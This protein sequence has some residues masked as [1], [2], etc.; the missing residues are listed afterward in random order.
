MNKKLKDNKSSLHNI[1]FRDLYWQM[2]QG[3][4]LGAAKSDSIDSNYSPKRN[5][6]NNNSNSSLPT[7]NV[8]YEISIGTQF[9]DLMV[10]LPSP[11][12]TRSK[13]SFAA[14]LYLQLLRNDDLPWQ[15][16]DQFQLIS[17]NN[18]TSQGGYCDFKSRSIDNIDNLFG[19]DS[20]EIDMNTYTLSVLEVETNITQSFSEAFGNLDELR[21]LQLLLYESAVDL[22]PTSQTLNKFNKRLH[23]KS[24]ASVKSSGLFNFKHSSISAN[25]NDQPESPIPDRPD[26]EEPTDFQPL[27][28]PHLPVAL[29]LDQSIQCLVASDFDP[30]C[31]KP[32]MNGIL[33]HELFNFSCMLFQ[34]L[35]DSIVDTSPSSALDLYELCILLLDHLD[36]PLEKYLLQKDVCILAVKLD[37]RE[38][39]IHHGQCVLQTM[40]LKKYDNINVL[41]Y[42]SEILIS[43]YESA[44][45]F[46]LAIKMILK[47]VNV[48]RDQ[49]HASV[50]SNRSDPRCRNFYSAEFARLSDPLILRLG[51]IFLTFGCEDKAADVLQQLLVSFSK[52]PPSM[53]CDLKKITVL[54]WLLEAYL[55][56]NN[57][58]ICNRIVE[59]IKDIRLQLRKPNALD[60]SICSINSMSSMS[61]LD[62]QLVSSASND[63]SNTHVSPQPPPNVNNRL[64]PQARS[65]KKLITNTDDYL[66]F[67]SLK[68]IKSKSAPALRTAKSSKKKELS[69]NTSGNS[70]TKLAIEMELNSPDSNLP[71]FCPTSHNTDL[72][73][74]MA[75][76]FFK[77]KL[78]IQALK[79]LT[80]TIIGGENL[81]IYIVVIYLIPILIVEMLVGGK[82]GTKEGMIE[83]G[84]LYYLRGKIQLEASKSSSDITY[85]FEVGSSQLFHV[86]QHLS[87]DIR[88]FKAINRSKRKFMRLEKSTM[89]PTTTGGI[90][91]LTRIDSM[92]SSSFDYSSNNPTR[93]PLA[94]SINSLT[95]KRGITYSCPSDILWDAMKW[96]RRSWDL[97][98][99]AGD[100]ISAA[101]SAN[102]IGVSTLILHNQSLLQITI[103]FFSKVSSRANIYPTCIF[104][105]PT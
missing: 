85:P 61:L 32:P 31:L 29:D 2:H 91:G 21:I 36:K 5:N 33:S 69:H 80:P 70:K 97:F 24:V 47:T 15:Q 86:I 101:K 6:N 95:C 10:L 8:V 3:V 49:F 50:E 57:F 77:A 79:S 37:R 100:E 88:K 75:R 83:L 99:C 34:H 94:N 1:S 41:M 105:S 102:Y 14:F 96:F 42:V 9:V 65:T 56:M 84:K 26:N 38:S 98:H 68:M 82:S 64:S 19:I 43:Q 22:Y 71:K 63:D 72:G 90:N 92:Q 44:A 45:Q 35:G 54:S 73:G 40:Q 17:V 87:S 28:F 58:T 51:K 23:K 62:E 52:R 93:S 60:L 103:R 66:S 30:S 7:Y 27:L 46:E 81:Y 55:A 16:T 104:P 11:S 13:L 59:V 89:K 76:I 25:T 48:L 78:Y 20:N 67:F 12:M 74:I 18:L 4:S 53:H 39:A